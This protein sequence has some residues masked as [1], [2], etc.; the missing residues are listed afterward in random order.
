M[1]IIF[2]SDTHNQHKKLVL[3][4]GDMIIH[5]GDISGRG[6]PHE[7]QA[8][9]DWYSALPYSYKIFIGGNHDFML[10]Q[11]ARQF[12]EIIPANCIYLRN[13]S[14]EIEGI[15]I[16]GSPVTPWFYDWAFNRHRGEDIKRYWDQIPEETDILITHG[17]PHGILD[18]TAR[19]DLA[20]CEELTEA[21]ARIKP[22][23]HAFGHIHEAYGKWETP[24][25][26]YLNASVLDLGYNL[27]NPP[28]LI[29]WKQYE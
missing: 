16:W 21:L 14:I 2:I 7:I 18:K 10:E 24:D 26:L 3:P 5:A 20:G 17:P 13:D 27:K 11:N 23:I 25:T 15:H 4:K 12:A 29:D 8:F 19:G 22:R 1:K 6:K 28:H 9:L